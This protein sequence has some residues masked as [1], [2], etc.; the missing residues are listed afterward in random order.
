MFQIL[1]CERLEQGGLAN[2]GFPKSVEVGD[3]VGLLDSEGLDHVSGIG[4]GEVGSVHPNIMILE[5]AAEK[6]AN[7]PLSF[8][9]EKIFPN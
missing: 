2:A 3:A 7:F 4:F 1:L 9:T 6:G 8:P 5:I